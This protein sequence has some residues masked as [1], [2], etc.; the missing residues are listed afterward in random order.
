[1]KNLRSLHPLNFAKI[2]WRRRWYTLATFIPVL[3][4]I[5]PYSL[6][7]PDTYL[8]EARIMVEPSSMPKNYGGPSDV[9]SSLEERIATMRQQIQSGI[10]QERRIKHFQQEQIATARQWIKSRSFLERLVQEFQLFDYGISK[11]FS[12]DHATEQIRK[13]LQIIGGSQGTFTISYAASD[14]MLAQSITRRIV[15]TLNQASTTERRARAIERN[16]LADEQLRHTAQELATHEEQIKQIKISNPTPAQEQEL[17]SL[18]RERKVLRQQYSLLS[19]MKFQAQMTADSNVDTYRIMD[20]PNLPEK[21]VSPNRMQL[22]LI[23]LGAGLLLAIGVA[24]VGELSDT[25]K[26][27]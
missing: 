10:F 9:Y 21:P 14:P 6:S 23:G 26:S 16:Q 8:S 13:N 4:A 24:L 3:V 11:R 2:L 22:N 25:T 18:S 5:C 27:S 12:M 19:A 1:M 17:M 7:I 15:E 20:E